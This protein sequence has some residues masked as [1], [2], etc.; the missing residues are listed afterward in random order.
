[1]TVTD[2]PESERPL[3]EQF[4]IVAKQWADVNG[5][6]QLMEETK[7]ANFSERVNR[8]IATSNEPMAFNRAEAI[9]KGSADWSE[10]L[11][12]M[13]NLRTKANRLKVQMEY[14]R[15]RFSEWQSLNANA[16]QERQLSR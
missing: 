9:V 5:A 8:E 12:D 11:T 4:R 16:R 1:M 2:M 3:S 14:I 7:T 15:M 10:Y 13:V 6:A